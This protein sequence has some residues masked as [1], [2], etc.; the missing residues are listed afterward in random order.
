[1]A[2]S[3][4]NDARLPGNQHTPAVQSYDLKF[5]LPAEGQPDGAVID[6]IVGGPDVDGRPS[7]RD[8]RFWEEGWYVWM[9][10]SRWATQEKMDLMLFDLER[11]TKWMRAKEM[12]ER[13]WFESEVQRVREN[14][15]NSNY[16]EA[17]DG[18]QGALPPA[19]V[20]DDYQDH[21]GP[22]RHPYPNIAMESRL[23]RVPSSLPSMDVYMRRIFSPTEH[24]FSIL[25][26]SIES[27][28][29]RDLVLRMWDTTKS[30]APFVLAKNVVR[31]C[32]DAF[33]KG[34]GSE[35]E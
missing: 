13:A 19:M 10:K 33:S 26:D 5:P 17:T 22:A 18:N 21:Y 20:P 7:A 8:V 4:M 23:I 1:M 9:T 24:L 27:G 32:W 16:P 29:Q 34:P 2:H 3:R 12:D 31:R 25:R 14:V 28:T 30:G 35:E 6:G 15:R 11:Q